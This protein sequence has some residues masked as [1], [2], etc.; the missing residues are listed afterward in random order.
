MQLMIVE[1]Y[2]TGAAGGCDFFTRAARGEIVETGPDGPIERRERV[3]ITD[4]YIDMDDAIVGQIC[5]GE[6]TMRHLAHALDMVD[7]WRVAR[8]VDDN[9]AL[10]GELVDLSRELAASRAALRFMEEME[11]KPPEERFIA[12]DN[13][14]HASR[15]AAMEATAAALNIDRRII[16]DAVSMPLTEPGTGTHAPIPSSETVQV[17][18]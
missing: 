11:H 10:R 12:L 16:A 13:S 17:A 4:R 15:R 5:V 8:I 14:E 1:E 2:P 6:R 9:H 7:G 3:I 18:Q